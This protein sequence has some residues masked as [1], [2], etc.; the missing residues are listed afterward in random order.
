MPSINKKTIPPNTPPTIAPTL[1]DGSVDGLGGEL[2]AVGLPSG[3]AEKAA[4]DS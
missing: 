3:G 4:G 1:V 2:V